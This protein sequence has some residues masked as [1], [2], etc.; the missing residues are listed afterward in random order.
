VAV[1]L[2]T[3]SA[4]TVKKKIWPGIATS[5]AV[6]TNF[7]AGAGVTVTTAEP[8][9]PLSTRFVTVIVEIVAVTKLKP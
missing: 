8:V 2:F 9:M 1:E 4:I 6:R 3:F 5:G 7:I